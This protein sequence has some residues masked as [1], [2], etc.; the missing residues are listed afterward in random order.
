MLL[1]RMHLAG[2]VTASNGKKSKGSLEVSSWSSLTASPRLTAWAV[3]V[4]QHCLSWRRPH[5]QAGPVP[6][7]YGGSGS[8]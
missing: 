6:H 7:G 3:S 4:C 1:A 8:P 2:G 5:P